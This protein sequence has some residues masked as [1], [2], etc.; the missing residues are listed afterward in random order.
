ML[1][2]ERWFLA[3]AIGWTAVPVTFFFTGGHRWFL[4][5]DMPLVAA[6]CY[7]FAAVFWTLFAV[8][9]HRLGSSG[10]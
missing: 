5:G 4:I 6:M 1:R 7:V 2:R 8:T 9:R 10:L 3:L